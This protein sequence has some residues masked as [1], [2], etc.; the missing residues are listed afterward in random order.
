MF[1]AQCGTAARGNAR[2]CQGCGAALVTDPASTA[3]PTPPADPRVAQPSIG[4]PA[5][6]PTSLRFEFDRLGRGDLVTGIASAVLFVSLLLPW[7][8]A[9][10]IV[11]FNVLDVRGWMYLVFLI[12]LAIIGY[13][14]L[15]A[16]WADLKL[17]IAHWQVLIGACGLNLLL[18]FFAFLAKPAGFTWSVGGFLALVAGIA[19]VVGSLVRR[20][21]PEQ[22][23]LGRL[24]AGSNLRPPRA[25]VAVEESPGHTLQAPQTARPVYSQMSALMCA[26]CGGSN[27][28]GNRFCSTCGTPF[29]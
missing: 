11:S 1:C 29:S 19:A 2:F 20:Q 13:L 3:G 7:Y 28:V 23:P 16:L 8:S 17:P 22:L 18:T 27:P 6:T 12:S 24:G 15:R 26:T 5:Q 10:G 25:P 21:E 9:A 14:V 4:Q